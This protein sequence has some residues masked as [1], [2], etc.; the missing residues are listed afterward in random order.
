MQNPV[1]DIGG[2]VSLLSAAAAPDIQTAAFRKYLTPDAGLK[3]PLC[4]VAP[5][6]GSRDK[7]LS[8]YEWYRI[9]SPRIDIEVKSVVYDEPN[10]ILLLDVA[11]TLHLRGSPFAPAPARL[12]VRFT[13]RDDATDG[14]HYIAL[15]EDFYHPDD[16]TA[17]LFPPLV[18][19]VRLGLSMT[20]SA[21]AI[22]AK[23]G[24]LLGFWTADTGNGHDDGGLY[25]DTRK[26]Q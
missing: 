10:H 8:V 3:N 1:A 22:Y 17:L 25:G 6:Q 9:L 12:L 26:T 11:Q 13:L 4:S 19:L 20:A 15:Q 14:L 24:Q 5:G 7:V 18:P 16:F 23:C 21:S 2:V